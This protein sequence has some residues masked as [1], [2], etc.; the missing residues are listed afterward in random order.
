MNTMTVGKTK[1]V[2]QWH[3]CENWIVD[4]IIRMTDLVMQFCQRPKLN[5]FV[6]LCS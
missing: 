6:L 2:T 3:K 1:R 4:I 5:I